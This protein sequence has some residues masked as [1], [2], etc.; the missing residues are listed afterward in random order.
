[1]RIIA[2]ALCFLC[3]VLNQYKAC[4]EPGVRDACG[5]WLLRYLDKAY[6]AAALTAALYKA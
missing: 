4:K 6:A 2:L 3:S 5:L 1:M